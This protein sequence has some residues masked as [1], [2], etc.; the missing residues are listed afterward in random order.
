MH[1]KSE[2][3][4]GIFVLS[5]FFIIFYLGS[6]IGLLQIDSIR[7]NSYT[8]YFSDISGLAKKADVKIAGVKVGWIDDIELFDDPKNRVKVRA[9]VL[10]NYNLHDDTYSVIKQDALLSNKYLEINPGT[11][12]NQNLISGS[13]ILATNKEPVCI[14]DLFSKL[15]NI[16][17]NIENITDIIKN[18]L[19]EKSSQEKINSTLENFN[20]A[21]KDI[22][23][24]AQKLE[25]MVGNNENNV[26][27]I[28]K[29][30]K[31]LIEVLKNQCPEICN[32]IQEV[33]DKINNGKGTLGK[34]INDEETYNNIKSGLC[35]LQKYSEK[36]KNCR[37]MLD[38]HCEAMTGNA[39]KFCFKDLKG[40]FNLRFYPSKDYFFLAGL[41]ASKK[42]YVQHK[43]FRDCQMCCDSGTENPTCRTEL[44]KNSV[45]LN[46]QVARQFSKLAF[47]AGIFEST[48]GLAAEYQ[49][50]IY[51]D[52]M[53]LITTLEAFDFKG[54]NHFFYDKSPHLKWLNQIFIGDN[55]S[56]VV[57]VDDFVSK[58]NKNAFVGAGVSISF[59]LNLQI[60]NQEHK[61][62]KAHSKMQLFSTYH[63]KNL[64]N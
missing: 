34:L 16:T 17:E 6:K 26:N 53:Q 38:T 7:Y 15:K 1:I 25:K 9:M 49:I 39:E 31:E 36:V 42:G 5:A 43:I 40:Y 18:I 29:D 60:Y 52:W 37:F 35:T 46:L 21:T 30:L 33:S 4:V 22:A 51:K 8:F 3:T 14:D 54:R 44:K 59:T 55:I 11:P 41:T 12:T 45:S 63:H 50:P 57:G 56:F 19:T 47:I 10:K 64:I 61:K 20:S 2:T 62:E 13:S 27:S 23:I 48:V 28:T 58:Y 24:I 32:N